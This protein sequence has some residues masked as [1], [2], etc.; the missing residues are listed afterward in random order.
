M[1][2]DG[3]VELEKTFRVDDISIERLVVTRRRDDDELDGSLLFFS[4]FFCPLTVG[5]FPR[6]VPTGHLLPRAVRW[7]WASDT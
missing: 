1:G 4:S 2:T 5:L 6:Y 7:K 3:I